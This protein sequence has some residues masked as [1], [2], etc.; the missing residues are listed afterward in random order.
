MIFSSGGNS[1]IVSPNYTHVRTANKY[2]ALFPAGRE[3][4]NTT[5]SNH[6]KVSFNIF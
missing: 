3:M 1:I 4:N 2:V 5:I 6:K